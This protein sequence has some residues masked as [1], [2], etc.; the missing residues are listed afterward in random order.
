M[1]YIRGN[2]DKALND[3]LKSRSFLD[4]GNLKEIT[5]IEDDSKY[6][7]TMCHFPLMSW[8]KS[9]YGSWSLCGHSHGSLPE[10]LPDYNIG[11][12]CDVG[13]DVALKFNDKFMFTFEDLK[14]IM[15]SKLITSHH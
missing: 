5:I 4:L 3:Y 6:S 12:R 7:I 14:L 11:K 10:S 1:K 9:H 2:H 13:I 15:D 8:N